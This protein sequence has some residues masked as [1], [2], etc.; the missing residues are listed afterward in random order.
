MKKLFENGR[1]KLI[2]VKDLEDVVYFRDKRNHTENFIIPDELQNNFYL[3]VETIEFIRFSIED[4]NL[5][6][7][8]LKNIRD[9][10]F[11]IFPVSQA[12]EK[13]LKAC[14]IEAKKAQLPPTDDAS[15]N[16]R[17]LR[18]SFVKKYNHYILD[19][20]TDL[21]NYLD[22]KNIYLIEIE[23]KRIPNAEKMFKKLD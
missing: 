20:L 11:I 7:L 16:A 22:N 3:T 21:T 13:L 15:D 1:Q 6:I 12:I 10:Q 23:I 2:A 19:I 9:Y 17:K 4:L 18:K 8:I 5:A 14:L